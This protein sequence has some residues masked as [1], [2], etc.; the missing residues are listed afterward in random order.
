M[1]RE[2][3][4]EFFQKRVRGKRKLH[5]IFYIFWNFELK[6]CRKKNYTK[7]LNLKKTLKILI[8]N[9]ENNFL[10]FFV[11]NLWNYKI[12]TRNFQLPCYYHFECLYACKLSVLC[13]LCAQH[14]YFIHRLAL[15][16][17]LLSFFLSQFNVG[18][19]ELS[20]ASIHT[21]DTNVQAYFLF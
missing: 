16:F 9:F 20:C 6:F 2:R 15:N 1:T 14:L 5:A 17:S 19:I 18:I 4:E 3:R 10:T 21:R 13:D 8:S 12:S 7:N 11:K